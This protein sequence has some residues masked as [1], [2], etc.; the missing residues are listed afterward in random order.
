MKRKKFLKTRLKYFKMLI[1]HRLKKA[2]RLRQ[3]LMD[4][5]IDRRKEGKDVN[6][7]DF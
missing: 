3:K 7:L 6:G 5:I 2:E 4:A 1:D